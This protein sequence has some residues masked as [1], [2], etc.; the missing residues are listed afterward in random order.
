MT[1][2]IRISIAAPLIFLFA[3][4]LFAQTPSP[5]M[6]PQSKEAPAAKRWSMPPM[7]KK[8]VCPLPILPALPAYENTTFF[9]QNDVPHGKVEQANY[10]TFS[11]ADKRVHVYL[12]PGY[13]KNANTRYPVL[14]LNHGGG[15][16]DSKWTSTDLRAGGNAQLILDNLIAAGKARP[17][18]VVM[19]NTRNCAS[20]TPSAPGK[21]DACTQEY[22]QNIIPYIDSHYRTKADRANRALAG[23]SMGG[24]VVMHTGMPHLDTF[25]ELYVYSSGHTNDAGLKQFAENFGP[26][27]KDPKTNDLFRVPYYMAAG[28]TDIALQN[29]QKVM[30]LFNQNGIRNFWV[31]SS[32]GHEWA[33][34][35]R[36]L[37]Q[38][39]QIMFPE[40][41]GN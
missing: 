3:C 41:P 33:N 8:G 26:L 5:G 24:F 35:R 10:K 2:R 6:D 17:M 21:D 20:A 13:E 15:D 23:L 16:D 37:Y 7:P 1:C 18:I 39:A 4:T 22:L 27:L 14:Y 11:G 38:T 9:A 31:L 25:S 28:E 36:Y 34:W 29:G 32:G 40:C 12:P 19:P 30:A